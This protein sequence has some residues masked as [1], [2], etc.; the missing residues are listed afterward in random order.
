MKLIMLSY[1]HLLVPTES[2]KGRGNWELF[3]IFS[4]GEGWDG[5]DQDPC[6]GLLG[7]SN[8]VTSILLV[9]SMRR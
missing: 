3:Q 7:P 4:T 8:G 1:R 6:N 2:S 5:M 9:N